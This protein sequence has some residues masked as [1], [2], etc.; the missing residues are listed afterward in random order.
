MNLEDMIRDA[1]KR[2]ELNH[3]SMIPTDK[4]FHA[5]FRVASSTSHSFGMH[6]DPV[7][8]LR[9]ALKNAKMVR[10]PRG[11]SLKPTPEPEPASTDADDI[12][13]G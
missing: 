13:F 4:G 11:P 9:I 10:A 7:E 6:E 8:A 2:G 3:L 5:A 1:A 12:D